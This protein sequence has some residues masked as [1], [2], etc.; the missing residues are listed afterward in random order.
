MNLSVGYDAA[1]LEEQGFK[2]LE[3]AVEL[4][5]HVFDTAGPSPS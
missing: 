5:D 3:R 2:I 4:G 1:P